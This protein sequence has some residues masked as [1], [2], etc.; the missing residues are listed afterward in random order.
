MGRCLTGGFRAPSDHI[1]VRILP[2]KV[3]RQDDSTWEVGP[4]ASEYTAC[5]YPA[6]WYHLLQH[7]GVGLKGPVVALTLFSKENLQALG[8]GQSP[9]N[10]ALVCMVS[11]RKKF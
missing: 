10:Q 7:L 6:K 2:F 11:P 4:M 3:G 8:K 9:N 5:V 1:L